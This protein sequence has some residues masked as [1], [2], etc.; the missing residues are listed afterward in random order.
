MCAIWGR[1]K[2]D[3]K[4]EDTKG[5]DLDHAAVKKRPEEVVG[6]PCPLLPWSKAQGKQGHMCGPTDTTSKFS[7]SRHMVHTCNP[8]VENNRDHCSRK[9][10]TISRPGIWFYTPPLQ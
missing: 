9:K 2:N 3:V 6:S 1:I 4:A 8:A 7:D 10:G 5:F